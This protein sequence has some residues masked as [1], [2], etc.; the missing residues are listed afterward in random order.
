MPKLTRTNGQII[1]TDKSQNT[2]FWIEN[3]VAEKLTHRTHF[4]VNEF[5]ASKRDNSEC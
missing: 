5:E 2:N 4:M 3:E 1:V